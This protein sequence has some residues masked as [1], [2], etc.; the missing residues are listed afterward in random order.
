[1]RHK[2]SPVI[3]SQVKGLGQG[4]RTQYGGSV[5]GVDGGGVRGDGSLSVVVVVS[6]VVVGLVLILLH[7]CTDLYPE[8]NDEDILANT[9]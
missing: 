4:F 7:T 2:H 9:A 3:G 8:L 5:G 1:M 6:V